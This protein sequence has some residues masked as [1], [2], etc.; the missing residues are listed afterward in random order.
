MKK[1]M[2]YPDPKNTVTCVYAITRRE[3]EALQG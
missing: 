3:W 2:E 1:I